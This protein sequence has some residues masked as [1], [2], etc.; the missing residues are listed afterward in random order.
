[1]IGVNGVSV[2][3]V[4]TNMEVKFEQSFENAI[5][6]L[7]DVLS[8]TVAPVSKARRHPGSRAPAG[9]GPRPYG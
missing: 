7:Y 3:D 4:S 8:H 5:V 1:M 9:G 2:Y 6:M